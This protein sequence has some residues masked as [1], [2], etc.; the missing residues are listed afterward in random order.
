MKNKRP[1][2][3][4]LMPAEPKHPLL[5][6]AAFIDQSDLFITGDTGVM[7]LAASTKKIEHAV[8]EEFV[9]RNAVK[10]IALFGGTH[11]GL[12]GYCKRTIISGRGRQEQARFAPG[13]VKD[14]YNPKGKDFFDNIAP[15]QLT[16]AIMSQL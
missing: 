9:P 13:I 4:F 14:M 15:Q 1:R 10:I 11:P 3:I 7:H 12:F 8:D 6:M 2:R 16:K 5:A